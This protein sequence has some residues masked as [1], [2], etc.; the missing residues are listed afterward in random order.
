M[1]IGGC[2]RKMLLWIISLSLF[3][4]LFFFLNCF[5]F[6]FSAEQAEL[7]AATVSKDKENHSISFNEFLQFMAEQ[8]SSEP[9]EETLIDMFQ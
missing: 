8:K 3:F 4:F 7:L 5:F 6:F 1:T 2:Y 9:D